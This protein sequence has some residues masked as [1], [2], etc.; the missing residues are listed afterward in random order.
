MKM[1]AQSSS[2]CTSTSP[3]PSSLSMRVGEGGCPS[4]HTQSQNAQS[5]LGDRGRLQG[6]L[7]WGLGTSLM[8]GWF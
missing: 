8:H 7:L 5:L 6:S 3:Q 2:T 4:Q 1:Q